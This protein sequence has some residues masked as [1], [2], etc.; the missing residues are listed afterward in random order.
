M[1]L[2]TSRREVARSA[3]SPSLISNIVVPAVAT[4]A[5]AA[6]SSAVYISLTT[7]GEVTATVIGRGIGLGGVL[8]G[9]GA[10]Y[11]LGP[12]AGDTMR[13]LGF[14]GENTVRPALTSGSRT[15]AMGASI[16]AGAATAGVVAAASAGGKLLFDLG[17]RAVNKWLPPRY[18]PTPADS[19][20]IVDAFAATP[21]IQ[22]IVRNLPIAAGFNAS[23]GIIQALTP[24]EAAEV[25][26]A[27]PWVDVGEDLPRPAFQAQNDSES[28]SETPHPAPSAALPT[29]SES[30]TQGLPG[31]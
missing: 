2:A 25:V 23:I 4:A 26:A 19:D 30:P 3:N 15:M 14:L 17:Q 5:G 11:L 27:A 12:V 28:E 18:I 13:I 7:T 1:E 31:Q 9:Q 24:L 10:E 16:V 29:V 20:A 21:R 22:G 8:L 6:V